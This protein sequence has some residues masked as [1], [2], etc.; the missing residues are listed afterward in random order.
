MEL[1][2][3]LSP[4]TT[5]LLSVLRFVVAVWLFSAPLPLRGDARWRV[6]ATILGLTALYVCLLVLFI[7]SASPPHPT[8][9]ALGE[10]AA[11]SLLLVGL[12]IAT[13][14]VYDTN[15]LT[16][17]FCCSSGYTVENF[18]SGFSELLLDL[19]F[20]GP[21]KVLAYASPIHHGIMIA[22]AGITYAITYVLVTGPLIKRG[23]RKVDDR[24]MLA[25]MVVVIAV[26][27]CFDLLIKGLVEAGLSLRAMVMLRAFHGLA[28]V[29]TLVVSL[30]LLVIRR[31][32]AERDTAWQVLAERERQYEASR[33][34][35]D[36]INARVHDI[37]HAI[38]RLANDAQVDR[39]VL[40]SIVREIDVYGASLRT[41]NPALDTVLAER[42]L[43]C[44]REGVALSCVADGSLLLFMSPADTYALFSSLFDEAIARTMGIPT[45]RSVSLTIRE[46]MG[47]VVVHLECTQRNGE[48]SADEARLAPLAALCDRY[49]AT[50]AT[51]EDD[52]A[53]HANV[54][55]PQVS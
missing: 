7:P 24:S 26:I 51:M 32:E 8:R 3:A 50:F 18:A 20:S 44:W 11:F 41:G 25:M 37:R 49:D 27:M 48:A 13:L 30:Q 21:D 6:P 10:L 16:A 12:V 2:W 15:V 43:T 47:N 38:G 42:G 33:E 36:A 17:V 19:L 45:S 31:V 52:G 9:Y 5:I 28:C 35:V 29:F 54:L 22:T 55:F 40:A 14:F 39:N 53:W 1:L 34:N 46:A 4:V 23:L